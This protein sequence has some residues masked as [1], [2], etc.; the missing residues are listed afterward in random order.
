MSDWYGRE[1]M[2]KIAVLNQKGG[3]GKTTI[4]AN[5]SHALAMAGKR[6]TAVDLDPQGHL[7]ASLGIFKP[8]AHGICDLLEQRRD[9]NA[10]K[11]DSRDSLQLVPAGTGL[12]EIEESGG[13]VSE[14]M[15]L[16]K[17]AIAN[18]GN[19]QDFMILDCPPSSGLLAANA[20]L[21]VDEVMVPVSGDYL[22]L[23]GLAHLMITLK[24][25][26]AVR[27][28]PINK[29]IVLSR[30]V[31]RR[32]LSR[33][34]LEKLKQHFPGMILKT[35]IREAAALAECPGVGRTIFEYRGT[36]TSAEDFRQLAQDVIEGNML[37]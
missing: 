8:P 33:E 4:T 28:R 17:H 13:V 26:D 24:R 27:E 6:V 34:V 2:K 19:D 35:P 1:E 11:I 20:I 16:L 15:H 5:L 18:I 25:F 22:S 21:A 29:K 3:V 14:R 32:R 31:S 10:V 37:S 12:R 23:N 9:F 36:S 7:T 30:F